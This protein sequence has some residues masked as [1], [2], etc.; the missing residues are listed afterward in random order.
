MNKS[1]KKKGYVAYKIDLQK[2]YDDVH[3]G[4][5]EQCLQDFGFPRI[6]IRLISI[7]CN[8]KRMPTFLPT[9]GLSQGTPYLFVIC[10]EKLSIAIFEVVQNGTWQPIKI[11]QQG[12]PMSHLFFANNILLFTRASSS[13]VIL[14][15]DLFALFG[16]VLGL[17]ISL[18][19]SRAY[20]SKGV[21][22][23]R[24]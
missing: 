20:Y 2:A 24:D 3:W 10:M 21:P 7:I 15:S 13:Q 1:K 6:T 9:C 22:R 18:T 19:K 14:V 4:Y 16:R 17:K 8:G 5:Q 12:P 23:A 11:S